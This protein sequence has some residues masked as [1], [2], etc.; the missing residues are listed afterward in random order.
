MSKCSKDTPLPDRQ[1]VFLNDALAAVAQGSLH[2]HDRRLDRLILTIRPCQR[3]RERLPKE[4][5]EFDAWRLLALTYRWCRRGDDGIRRRIAL[6][7]FKP[8]IDLP[9]TGRIGFRC[10]RVFDSAARGVAHAPDPASNPTACRA[11]VLLHQAAETTIDGLVAYPAHMLAR[12]VGW[13]WDTHPVNG[14][15]CPFLDDDA[16]IEEGT[17][18]D[19]WILRDGTP[20]PMAQAPIAVYAGLASLRGR[21]VR[22][23]AFSVLQ[24]HGLIPARFGHRAWLETV[25]RVT[26]GSDG[27][28]GRFRADLESFV[29]ADLDDHGRSTNLDSLCRG[30]RVA[31]E[32]MAIPVPEGRDNAFE[33]FVGLLDAP[34]SPVAVPAAAA[35]QVVHLAGPAGPE[36]LVFGNGFAQL[37]L[38][39]LGSETVRYESLPRGRVRRALFGPTG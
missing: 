12:P 24:K 6:A 20:T 10:E 14:S 35:L 31:C 5:V 19:N 21:A 7:F 33:F 15:S 13:R 16:A 18:R 27:P 4:P 34:W 17:I 22:N 3:G 1:L 26:D 39:D 8:I 32:A 37:N 28:A 36:T 9:G 2:A 30:L 23:P 38:Y 25:G 29:T 11:A